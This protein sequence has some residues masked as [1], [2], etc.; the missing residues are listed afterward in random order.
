MIWLVHQCR[1]YAE[2]SKLFSDCTCCQSSLLETVRFIEE[3]IDVKTSRAKPLCDCE[4]E[5]RITSTPMMKLK[6]S[7][8]IVEVSCTKFTRII[9]YY[10]ERIA[11]SYHPKTGRIFLIEGE[12]CFSNLIHETL[13][14]RSSLSQRDPPP[15]NLLFVSEGLTELLVGLILKRNI[16]PC[17]EKWQIV[18]SCFLSPYAKFVKP[19]LFL[20]YK[21]DLEPIISLYFNAREQNPLEQL[22]NY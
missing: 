15:K 5:D 8:E 11:G 1:A 16:S 18:N 19:W 22:G 10:E 3:A 2:A 20:T 21:V 9:G 4:V 6:A 13:H 7:Q 14:S 17:Y 12:W